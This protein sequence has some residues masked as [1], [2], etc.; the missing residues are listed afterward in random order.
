MGEYRQAIHLIDRWCKRASSYE[1]GGSKTAGD[2]I[3]TSKILG[4]TKNTDILR[5]F[6]KLLFKRILLYSDALPAYVCMQV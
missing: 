1:I 2:F 6:C 5:F 4:L 3:A